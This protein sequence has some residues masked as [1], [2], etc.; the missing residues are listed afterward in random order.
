MYKNE[1]D[2]SPK[3]FKCYL[4]WGEE[5]YLIEKYADS[6]AQKLG[7]TANAMRLYFDEYDFDTAKNYLSQSSLFA[8]TNLLIVKHDKALSK[9]ELEQL[10]DICQK[11]QNSYFIYALL[12]N[13]GKKISSLFDKKHQSVHVRFFPLSLYEAKKELMQYCQEKDIA[14][15]NYAL[16][17]LLAMLQNDLQLAKSELQKLAIVASPIESKDIDRLVFPLT[18][19]N[20]EKLYIAIIKKEPIEKL[21]AKMLEEEP[22]EMKILLGFENFLQQLFLFYSYIRLHGNLD[23]S[24]I[25]GYKLPRHIEEERMQLAIRIKNYPKI[26]LNLQECEYLLKTKTDVD[27]SALLLS[28][29]IKVQGLF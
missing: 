9:K 22:N 19:L 24:K 29:L 28:Y 25:L 20:L 21:L 8:D 13:E 26:F 10:I 11:N 5:H 17:H 7:D 18:P 12:S 1:F 4:F 27:K 6:I 16:E 14:I 23:S 3:D 15:D 2:K